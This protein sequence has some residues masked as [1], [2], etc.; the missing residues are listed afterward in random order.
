MIFPHIIWLGLVLLVIGLYGVVRFWPEGGSAK[1][2]SQHI[3]HHKAGVLYYILLFTIVLP[4]FATFFY[5]WFIPTYNPIA[6]FS[7]LIFI[8]L[9]AQYLCTF[10]PEVGTKR[11]AVHQGLAF[12]SA[13]GLLFA[14]GAALLSNSFSI[15]DKVCLAVGFLAMTILLSVL[16]A[17]RANHPKIL[18]IQIGY[19]VAFFASILLVVYF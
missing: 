3:A 1:T 9:L 8:G 10:V 17:A 6:I 12:I 2:F 7:T 11:K 13:L 15:T 16:I 18:Y 4:I 5:Y 19:F 14:I